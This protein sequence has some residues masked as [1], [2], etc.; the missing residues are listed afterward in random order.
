MKGDGYV[1]VDKIL[2]GGKLYSKDK[3]NKEYEQPFHSPM[4]YLDGTEI[5]PF[6][7]YAGYGFLDTSKLKVLCNSDY[8]FEWIPAESFG[9]SELPV[10]VENVYRI[11][12]FK[13]T[14]RLIGYN[15]YLDNEQLDSIP[16]LYCWDDDSL[17]EKRTEISDIENDL[18]NYVL[19][20]DNSYS[21]NYERI[22]RLVIPEMFFM[23]RKAHRKASLSEVEEYRVKNKDALINFYQHYYETKQEVSDRIEKPKVFVK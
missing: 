6:H 15:Y 19:F 12:P 11:N 8:S 10:K 5:E 23:P 18:D 1:S 14:K 9:I 2:L 16:S 4:I 7:C 3:M 17:L 21:D 22:R 20:C 13:R